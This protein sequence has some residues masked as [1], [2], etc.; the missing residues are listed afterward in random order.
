MYRGGGKMKLIYIDQE[1]GK[2]FEIRLEKLDYIDEKELIT[3]IREVDEKNKKIYSAMKEEMCFYRPIDDGE[4]FILEYF[5]HIYYFG[6]DDYNYKI[7]TR[8]SQTTARYDYEH[9]LRDM[10]K[11]IYKTGHERKGVIKCLRDDGKLYKHINFHYFKLEDRLV[12]IHDDQTEIYMYRDSTINDKDVGIAIYQDNKIVEVNERFTKFHSKTREELIG[13]SQDLEGI[14]QK[15]VETLLKEVDSIINQ[16]K[17]TY[18]TPIESYDKDGN[19]KYYVHAEGS[20]ITYDNMPAV[21]FKFKDLTEQEKTKR[22]NETNTDKNI[23]RTS[24]INELE[25]ISK[26]FLSYAVYPDNYYVTDN[27]YDVIEDETRE[28]PFKKGTIRDFIIGQDIKYYDKMIGSLSPSNHEVEFTT[29]IMTLKLNIKY[30]KHYFRRVYDKEGKAISYISSHQDITDEARYSNSLKKQIYEK[31]QIIMDKD[32]EIKEAHHTIKNNLNILLSLIRMQEH[33]QPDLEKIL[34]DTKTHIKSI[35]LMHEKLYQSDTLKDIELKEYIDS[36]V[37]S[38]FDIYSSEI[39]YVSNVDN[40]V[41][42][43]HQAGTLGLIINEL[44]NN[45]VKYA[46]PD[47]ISG[48]VIIRITRID[49]I[50]EVEYR[51]TGVGIPDTVDFK[52]PT[53]LGLTVI[54]NL[55]KQL[56]GKI[57]YSYD[58]GS[59]IKLMFPEKEVF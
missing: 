20:Y 13:N 6:D 47:N 49:K 4:D 57:A 16:E 17:L 3:D 14:P 32:M 34:E 54:K 26:T 36:I 31:N 37:E 1:Q 48:Q 2:L 19:L 52:N 38:L 53:S 11:D 22:R 45:T 35:S 12:V 40:I 44:L 59:C 42:N 50:I 28:Y 7:G 8:V 43:S 18:K 33:M 25:Q 46:F 23:R 58:N 5:N 9:K 15:F 24:T 27:F 39:I 55:T 21:Q 29:S 56:D 51:D 41:L 10:L 30:I